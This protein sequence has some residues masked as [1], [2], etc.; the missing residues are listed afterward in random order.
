VH[1][2]EAGRAAISGEYSAIL[3]HLWWVIAY[4]VVVMGIA[5]IVFTRKMRSDNN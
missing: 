2:V 5:I 1:A 3:P 4:A